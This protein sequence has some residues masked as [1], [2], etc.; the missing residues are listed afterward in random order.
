MPEA[1]LAALNWLNRFSEAFAG[2]NPGETFAALLTPSGVLRDSLVF[3]WDVRSLS[4]PYTIAEYVACG[5]EKRGTLSDAH[6]DEVNGSQLF[7]AFRTTLGAGRGSAQLASDG[8][9]EW[10][11]IMLDKLDDH[12]EA[13][14]QDS[15]AYRRMS[16]QDPH[17]VVGA[18][19]RRLF[20]FLS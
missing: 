7:F 20:A 3:S 17:V 15:L 13:I 19:V 6:L 18:S 10:A 4:S 11:F 5:I 9:A 14:P 16:E 1:Q 2:P 8:K 12:D